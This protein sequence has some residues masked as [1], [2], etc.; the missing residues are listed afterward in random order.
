MGSFVIFSLLTKLNG[1]AG[2]H[3]YT[4][5]AALAQFFDHGVS[6]RSRIWAAFVRDYR[7]GGAHPF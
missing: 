4:Y 3:A 2:T 5:I 6:V 1:A 7:S